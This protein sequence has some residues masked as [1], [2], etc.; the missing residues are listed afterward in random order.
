MKVPEKAAA[1]GEAGPVTTKEIR[2]E[3]MRPVYTAI[4][5]TVIVGGVY[6]AAA[7]AQDTL[8]YP[9]KPVRVLVGLSPGGANDLQARLFA[10]KLGDALGKTFIVE[11]R[12]GAGGV[13]AYR[14]VVSAAPDGYTA[15]RQLS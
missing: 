2:G 11:N 9:R 1:K 4:A 5:A 14:T 7:C 15:R 12:P 10:Q 3:R 13:V 6:S 8:E